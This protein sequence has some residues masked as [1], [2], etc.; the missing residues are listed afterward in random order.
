MKLLKTL[1]PFLIFIFFSINLYAENLNPSFK[2]R[3][4]I[5]SFTTTDTYQNEDKQKNYNYYSIVIPE[6]I[7][8]NLTITGNY[9]LQSEKGPLSIEKDI[10]E[11]EKYIKKLKDLGLK[12]N[13][14]YIVTGS[15]NVI[16]NKL[17][18]RVTIF[19]VR[20]ENLETVNHESDELGAQLQETTDLISQSIHTRIESFE[21][22]NRENFSNSPFITLYAPLSLITLGIDSGYFYLFGPWKSIYKNTVYIS[23]FVDLDLTRNLMISLKFTSIQTDS[24]NKDSGMSSSSQIRISSGSLSLSYILRFNDTLGIAFSAGGGITKTRITIGSEKPFNDSLLAKSTFDPNLDISSY[25][26]CNFSSINLRAGIHYKRIF[27]SG[28]PMNTGTVFAGA[29]IHF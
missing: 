6:T 23:P 15:F 8:K 1:T 2:N 21:L 27:Y 20:G 22:A 16:N 12:Y 5:Y 10:N 19:N 4:L 14:N 11:K 28:E 13:V 17:I 24:E 29:G 9:E 18:I 26:S 3:I 7:K 25:L